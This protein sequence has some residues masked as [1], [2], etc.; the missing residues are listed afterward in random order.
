MGPMRVKRSWWVG[1]SRGDGGVRVEGGFA[2]FE[3]VFCQ[4]VVQVLDTDAGTCLRG[5]VG[6]ISMS[7]CMEG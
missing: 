3:V 6:G 1:V 7:F 4:V 5:A 2:Y